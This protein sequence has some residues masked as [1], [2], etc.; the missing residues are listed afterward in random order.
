MR[1]YGLWRGRWVCRFCISVDLEYCEAWFVG[2]PA[3]RCTLIR[4]PACFW[5]QPAVWKSA[6]MFTS[7]QEDAL[8]QFDGLR[9]WAQGFQSC[10][11]LS[12]AESVRSLSRQGSRTEKLGPSSDVSSRPKRAAG[13]QEFMVLWA[14][15]MGVESFQNTELTAATNHSAL[16]PAE[17]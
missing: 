4:N 15:V 13:K 1:R 2:D 6:R 12:V 17:T 3:Q 9:C 10:F 16:A 8:W 11:I 14:D 7:G 5:L